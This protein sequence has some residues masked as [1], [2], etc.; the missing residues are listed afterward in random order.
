M[1]QETQYNGDDLEAAMWNGNSW[2]GGKEL[3]GYTRGGFAGDAPT[4]STWLG[5]TGEAIIVY[6]DEDKTDL[7]AWTKWN[8]SSWSKQTNIDLVGM[9]GI[10]SIKLYNIVAEDKIYCVIYDMTTKIFILTYDGTNWVN[11]S[12]S[13]ELIFQGIS[14]KTQPFE[15][16]FKGM[17]NE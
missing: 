3:D 15:M 11:T 8:G 16:V 17:L 12:V 13:E 5:D 9:T 1:S 4:A 14:D 6:D 7:F 2:E 10:D